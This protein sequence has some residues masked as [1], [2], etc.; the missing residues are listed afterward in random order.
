MRA[1]SSSLHIAPMGPCSR[2]E[3]TAGIVTH[4][5]QGC[6][7]KGAGINDDDFEA[8]QAEDAAT[9]AKLEK[10]REAPTRSSSDPSAY[11]PPLQKS[12]AKK[13]DEN[14]NKDAGNGGGGSQGTNLEK[15]FYHSRRKWMR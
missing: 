6:L 1:V 3:I 13:E 15:C 4:F 11:L 12:N 10:I 14:T 7:D 2:C 5:C 8:T 9:V